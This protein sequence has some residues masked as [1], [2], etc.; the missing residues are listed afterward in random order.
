[1]AVAQ[2]L[3]TAEDSAKA[4][5]L[6]ATDVDGDVLSYAIVSG[7]AHGTLSGVAPSLNY[8]PDAN[9][10][11]SD[12]F[13]FKANDGT[14][15][16][17]PAVVSIT[18]TPVNDAPIADAQTIATDR[19]VAKSFALTGSD[20]DGD[21]LTYA[22]LTQPARGKLSGTAPNLTYT[23]SN[24][25]TGVDMFTFRV[26]DGKTNSA[27]A[28][29]TINIAQG[30]NTAPVASAQDSTTPED[31]AKAITLSGT[32]ADGDTL[33]YTV[34]TLPAHGVLS[35]TAPNLI[36]QPATNYNGSDT[37][38]FKAND[39]QA[40]SALAAVTI[41]VTPVNDAPVAYAQSVATAEDTTKVITLSATDVDIDPLTYTVVTAPLHGT[42]SGVAPNLTYKPA[43]NYNGTDSF[44]FKANDGKLD[45]S[46]ATVSIN[47]TPVNQPPVANSQS[48]TT[49]E[50]AAKAITLAATD[51]DGDVLSYSV[52]T[53]PAHGA[54]TG[55]GAN[56]TYTPETNYFGSDSFTFK[57]N[58]GQLDSATATVSIT[59][60]P[61]N[62]VPVMDQL[63][64]ITIDQD[65][66]AQTVALSGISPGPN[67]IQAL[68]IT[69]ESSN[70]SLIPAP[71]INYSDPSTVGS[72]TFAPVAGLS[73]S[74]VITVTLNDGQAANNIAR[75][76]FTI[77]VN[78]AAVPLTMDPIP[79]VATN[80]NAAL[81]S[82]ALTGISSSS[83]VAG[84]SVYSPTAATAPAISIVAQSSNPAL[85]PD[86]VV[87]YISPNATG[88][89]R[90]TPVPNVS[91]KA[92]IRVTVD[93][94]VN[95]PLMRSFTVMIN[96]VNAA[97]TLDTLA[98]LALTNNAGQQTVPLTGITAGPN[99]SQPLTITAS[100]SNPGVIPVP[101][102]NYTSPDGTGS[103]AFTPVA[104]ASGSSLITVT[105]SDGQPTNGSI[106]RSFTVTVASSSAAPTIALTSP[107]AGTSFAQLA[108][109]NLAVN[110]TPNGHTLNKV[111]YLLDGTSIGESTA[112]P[113]SI[114]WNAT[115]VGSFS[116]VARLTYDGSSSVDSAPVAV[117][118]TGLPL[119][120]VLKDIGST[121]AAGTANA[122]N[123]VFTLSG[124][125]QLGGNSDSFAYVEQPLES[126][127]EIKVR[128]LGVGTTGSGPRAG[129]M[130]RESLTSG[131]R[132]AFLGVGADGMVR[133]QS[134]ESVSQK[135][136]QS[137]GGTATSVLWVRLV[138]SGRT[139]TGYSSADGLNWRRVDS[140]KASLATSVYVGLA[141]ASGSQG[142]LN[143]STFAN[144][145]AVP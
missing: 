72:L 107:S 140:M 67:E 6:T 117:S 43:T 30:L 90:I 143:T 64:N 22:V 142:V 44:T 34:T 110:V 14:V 141:V 13:T 121:G 15:D 19:N 45:S 31:T 37:L 51:I 79:N 11:G 10:N 8:I 104:N 80:E 136:T 96:E 73:G 33:T 89:L 144:P 103:L 5:T 91:G 60:T 39:G 61:V 82:V 40:D 99:E 3:T 12:S 116:L 20:V 114:S 106:S 98:S 108:K 139:I 97:P 26:N 71:R 86:P 84:A 145:V 125:G 124:A 25:I 85:V 126:D 137:A 7:P 21:T 134:R 56:L 102:V 47:V 113:Y 42:L 16:S 130:I 4:I 70:P 66:S 105:V 53:K 46:T 109:V 138:R 2:S 93:D 118:V 77:A 58:D 135:T 100:S 1:V 57:A 131:S 123:Q 48:V 129:V 35:G 65:S 128:I 94:G 111:Q 122:S 133:W 36:Y 81:I 78:P 49:A 95:T 132:F 18:V 38:W 120:W 55:V 92:I 115:N 54:L 27:S 75:Y 62:D 127:G 74:A 24:N 59:V 63:A 23:P 87:E 9:Y 52:L 69:A 32:D 76:T 29:V 68:T 17:T 119:P 41:T 88:T 28:V 112:S 50:D 83:S 101:T